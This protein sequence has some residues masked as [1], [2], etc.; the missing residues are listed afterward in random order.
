MFFLKLIRLISDR[1][2]ECDSNLCKNDEYFYPL[3]FNCY[4][5]KH[6]NEFYLKVYKK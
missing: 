4:K 3:C 2:F 6:P 1:C 5:E